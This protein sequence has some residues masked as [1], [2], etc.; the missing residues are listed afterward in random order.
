MHHPEYGEDA[1]LGSLLRAAVSTVC[2]KISI[3]KEG[4]I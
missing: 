4:A 3:R 2:S 1:E